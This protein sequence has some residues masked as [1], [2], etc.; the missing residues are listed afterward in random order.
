MNQSEITAVPAGE[1]AAILGSSSGR[2][3]HSFESI[4]AK[5][6]SKPPSQKKTRRHLQY[7]DIAAP[8]FRYPRTVSQT[9]LTLITLRVQYTD[10]E[11]P[12]CDEACWT[13]MTFTNQDSLDAEISKTSAEVIKFSQSGSQIVTVNMGWAAAVSLGSHFTPHPPLPT[14]QQTAYTRLLCQRQSNQHPQLPCTPLSCS[15]TE[16]HSHL[17]KPLPTTPHTTPSPPPHPTSSP[18]TPRLLVNTAGTP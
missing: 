12:M 4:K 10:E 16:T 13:A 8:I 15:H 7:D 11:L 14:K 6:S 2:T 3:F 5:E 1:P 9:A 18:S 17:S